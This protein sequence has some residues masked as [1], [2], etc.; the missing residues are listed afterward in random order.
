VYRLLVPSLLHESLL[1]LFQNR[2]E[3]APEMLEIL[4]VALPD[5]A[6][7]RIESA[8]FN[9]II[10]AE[11]RADLVVLLVN[12]KPVFAIVVEV[13]LGVDKDKLFSWPAYVVGLHARFKCPAAVLVVAVDPSVV[14]WASQAIPLGPGF[15]FTPYVLGPSAVPTI[16]DPAAAA[17]DPELA[18]LS[19]MAHGH[20][21]PETAARI[22][23]AA[24]SAVGQLSDPDRV[25]LYGDLILSALSEA[26]RKALQMIPQGYEFQ[27]P[28]IRES[29][30]KGEAT[31]EARGQARG[32]L[33][34]LEIRGVSVSATHRERILSCTDL[35][36]L[37][38]WTDRAVTVT[39]ADELFTQ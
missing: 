21:D 12:G 2:P 33:R 34:V 14:R 26:A 24:T 37:N 7:A 11:Y 32:V 4:G 27:S 10:P 19:A 1:L 38:I 15:S 17:A 35:D 39:S 30:Q 9:N 3:L 31:G 13:Q 28:I 18:V 25:V 6:S 8:N 16:T 23:L 20:G 36:V 5:Y 29:I 22:G